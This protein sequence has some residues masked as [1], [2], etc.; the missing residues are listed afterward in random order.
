[1]LLQILK[2][3]DTVVN[4][5][6]TVDTAVNTKQIPDTV[7]NTEQTLDVVVNT[8]LFPVF[9]DTAVITERVPDALT[10]E[11][12]PQNIFL[13]LRIFLV[14]FYF[15]DR[16]FFPANRDD[17]YHEVIR[18]IEG[19]LDGTQRPFQTLWIDTGFF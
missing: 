11:Y 1:M 10:L 16:A 19:Q 12:L 7:V 6:W 3:F 13:H 17:S 4:S 8:Y 5:E 18:S 14:P 2:T 9:P 15:I